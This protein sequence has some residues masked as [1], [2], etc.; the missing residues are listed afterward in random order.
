MGE[1]SVG[2]I[3]KASGIKSRFVMD[4]AGILDPKRMAPRIPERPNEEIS[5]LAE[6]A[7]AAAREAMQRAGKTAADIDGVICACSNMQRAYPAMAV[8]V[9]TALGIQGWGYDMNVACSSATFGLQAANSAV[10]TGQARC[11]LL[12]CKL[13]ALRARQP[14]QPPLL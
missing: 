1:S 7:V 4:K 14:A 8:E 6:M 2:F 3:E 5:I 12:V 9:Q 10:Q 13:L 11:L